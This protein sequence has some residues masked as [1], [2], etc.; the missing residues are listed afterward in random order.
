[1]RAADKRHN[2]QVRAHVAHTRAVQIARAAE[3]PAARALRARVNVLFA[4]FREHP[5]SA[6]AL[7]LFDAAHRAIDD[8]ESNP[9]ESGWVF[10]A[11]LC[12]S[13]ATRAGGLL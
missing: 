10:T 8:F 7:V 4:S 6:L 12:A 5:H 3:L 1:M 2:E 9:S 13:Y 11:R